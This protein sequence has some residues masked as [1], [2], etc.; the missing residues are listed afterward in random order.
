MALET[1]DAVRKAELAADQTEKEAA[2]QAE[3]IIAKARQQAK[4]LVEQ[5]TLSAREQATRDLQ[6]A[7]REG[8]ALSAAAAA[9]VLGERKTL[10]ESAKAKEPQAIAAI[11]SELIDS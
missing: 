3:Q 5:L 1:I 7:R 4:E 2:A 11:L 9:E 8:E 6:E 10:Q